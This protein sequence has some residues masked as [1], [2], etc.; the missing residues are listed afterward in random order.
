MDGSQV[1]VITSGGIIVESG[2]ESNQSIISAT[3]L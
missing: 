2:Y 3:I 1:F